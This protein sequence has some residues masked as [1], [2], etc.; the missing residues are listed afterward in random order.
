MHSNRS[1]NSFLRLSRRF[2][3]VLQPWFPEIHQKTFS[4][5]S[6]IGQVLSD[7][8]EVDSI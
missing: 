1:H 6:G 4:G 3:G 2:S 5:I 8:G 7:E